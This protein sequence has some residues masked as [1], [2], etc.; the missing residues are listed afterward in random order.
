MR[1]RD[2][3]FLDDLLQVRPAAVNRNLT[4]EKQ[5]YFKLSSSKFY[6]RNLRKEVIKGCRFDSELQ[7]DV[8][9]SWL[10][11]ISIATSRGGFTASS[12]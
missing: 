11:V 8:M 7:I 1:C 12:F 5:R 3:G 2:R 4:F 6:Q 10:A 9:G